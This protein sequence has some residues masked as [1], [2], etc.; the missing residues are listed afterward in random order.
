[1]SDSIKRT[2]KLKS[3]SKK[4]KRHGYLD[5]E[6]ESTC[7]F[8][9]YEQP[10]YETLACIRNASSKR[11]KQGKPGQIGPIGRDGEK[12]DKGDKGD[13]GIG[14]SGIDGANGVDGMNGMNGMDG[15]NGKDG[16]NGVDGTNGINGTNGIDGINGTNG[17]NG[18][19]GMNGVNGATGPIGPSG[20]DGIGYIGPIGPSGNDGEDGMNGIDGANGMDG[21][22]G[23]NGINGINGT[24]GVDGMDGINGVN[25][26]NGMN[27]SIGP[28]GP[29]GPSGNDGNDGSD[30]S[31]GKDG[32]NGTNGINGTNGMNGLNGSIGPIGPIGPQGSIPTNANFLTL[33]V[34]STTPI[35]TGYAGPGAGSNAIL[36]VNGNFGASAL[37]QEHLLQNNYPGNNTLAI[38]NVSTSNAFSAARFL[39]ALGAERMAIGYGNPDPTTAAFPFQSASYIEASTFVNADGTLT[40]GVPPP[41]R[42]VLTGTIQNI[43]YQQ[44]RMELSPDGSF[45][46]YN[47]T[48]SL[49]SQKPI[50]YISY[51]GLV[52]IG[53][54]SSVSGGV[55]AAGPCN[56]LDVYGGITVGATVTGHTNRMNDSTFGVNIFSPSTSGALLRLVRDAIGK[57]DFVYNNTGVGK[58]LDLT[59]TDNGSVVPISLMLDGSH[60]VGLGGLP[61]TGAFGGGQ[62]TVFLANAT[63]LPTS[64]PTGGGLLYVNNGALTYKGSGPNGTVTV[65]APP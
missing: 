52:G 44:R 20:E 21:T 33:T 8:K 55:G 11:G 27:G 41:M 58:R 16:V 46:Y 57:V 40:F 28:I 6:Q 42:F 54:G 59:D 53:D 34:G 62:G 38:Q 4:T 13:T 26:I 1:M 51:N 18:V 50:F 35:R 5:I 24:N 31:D 25:G 37:G 49:S 19:D 2:H 65:L 7:E 56:T 48:N 64:T 32:M 36:A 29:I 10:P 39:T 9:C 17:V 14:S 43:N 3:K 22:N 23:I 45:N 15:T 12:G 30:G 63:T 47:V 61:P 60:N